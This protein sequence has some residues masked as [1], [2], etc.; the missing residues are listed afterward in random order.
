M[1]LAYKCD[2]CGKLF[3]PD[4]THLNKQYIMT[5]CPKCMRYFVEYINKH[6]TDNEYAKYDVCPDCMGEITSLNG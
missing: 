1:A 2:I 4:I 3:K 5:T 6:Y